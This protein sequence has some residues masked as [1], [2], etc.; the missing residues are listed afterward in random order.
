MELIDNN[1]L[2]CADHCWL[3][4]PEGTLAA[5]AVGPIVHRGDLMGAPALVYSWQIGD[6]LPLDGLEA[7]VHIE[8]SDLGSVL[9][10]NALIPV[11]RADEAVELYEE[12]FGRAFY[13]RRSDG[14]L[15]PNS[16][17][18]QPHALFH[19][20]ITDAGP[21]SGLVRV[22]VMAD[23]NGKC[24]AAAAVHAMNVMCGFEE[25]LGIS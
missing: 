2:V 4:T 1:P 5:I 7:A 6:E 18:D 20:R 9:A 12:A 23:R 13:V 19:V 24:G 16:V 11:R 15:N 8:P 14:A 17:R 3:P 10:L 25:T 22:S 21:E